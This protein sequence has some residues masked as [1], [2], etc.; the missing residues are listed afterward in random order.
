MGV[1]LTVGIF[2]NRENAPWNVRFGGVIVIPFFSS[3]F[4]FNKKIEM[5]PNTS[6]Q[7]PPSPVLSCDEGHQKILP[8][9]QETVSTAFHIDT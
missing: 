8:P 2:Q 4:F 5:P 1:G 9:A 6:F 3:M 7:L